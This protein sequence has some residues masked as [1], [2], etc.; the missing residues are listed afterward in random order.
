MSYGGSDIDDIIWGGL[1]FVV[2]GSENC[3][4]G[5]LESENVVGGVFSKKA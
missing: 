2:R 4:R 1:K 3:R 5:G